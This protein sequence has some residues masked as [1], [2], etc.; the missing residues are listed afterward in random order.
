MKAWKHYR[1]TSKTE[2]EGNVE[3]IANQYTLHCMGIALIIVA[4]VW[5]LDML[6]IFIIDREIT[7]VAFLLFLALYCV[8]RIFFGRIDLSQSWVKYCIIFWAVALIT[9]LTTA[10]TYQ[11]I[12]AYVIPIMYTSMY[13][14]NRVLIFSYILMVI[15]SF[16]TVFAGYYWGICD[17]NM[18]LLT[19]G[20]LREYTLSDNTFAL[21]QINDDVV[22]TLTLYYV[23]PRCMICIVF[24]M[25]CRSI[26]KIISSNVTHA[27]EMEHLAEVD[28]MTGVYN[29]SKY[30]SMIHDEYAKEKQLAVIF[31]DINYLKKINDT[32]GHE[33]GDKLILTISRIIRELANTNDS[34]Y[35]I[36][37][38]EFV[39]IMR[40]GDE[41]ALQAK[42][43]EWEEKLAQAAETSNFPLS[44]SMGYAAGSGSD[45]EAVIR[46]ADQMMYENK[47]LHH[48][49]QAETAD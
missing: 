16:V 29:K 2:Y 9:I 21:S 36:G 38:D 22:F 7:T 25:I 19:T 8:G 13:P 40:G 5:V 11:A 26:S 34:A 12:L 28:Q 1:E 23:I 43:Q 30:L 49:R 18:V 41:K 35:R 6:E 46:A 37:G 42:V 27:R 3:L 14:S 47:R 44:A 32:Q 39:M 24:T 48:K 17:A 20:P 31:W 33:A 4:V 15:S 45:L 10:F